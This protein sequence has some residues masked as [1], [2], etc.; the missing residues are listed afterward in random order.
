MLPRLKLVLGLLLAAGALRADEFDVLRQKWS[1]MLTGGSG[2]NLAETRT[3]SAVTSI[4]N[5]ANA[6]GAT[7]VMT[8]AETEKTTDRRMLGRAR[9]ARFVHAITADGGP[10]FRVAQG[11]EGAATGGT[12]TNDRRR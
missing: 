6:E 10:S 8:N 2:L 3:A 7:S 11:S 4:T 12:G 1:D 5:A 9:S